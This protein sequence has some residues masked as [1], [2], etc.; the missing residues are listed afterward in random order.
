MEDYAAT[1]LG[2]A[3]VLSGLFFLYVGWRS[4]SAA[5]VRTSRSVALG[6]LL[7]LGGAAL[8]LYVRG[9]RRRA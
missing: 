2:A 9:F 1:Y 5:V 7:L 8:L 3:W 6:V 4:Q